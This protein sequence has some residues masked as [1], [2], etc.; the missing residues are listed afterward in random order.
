[1]SNFSVSSTRVRSGITA[2]LAGYA[3]FATTL[4]KAEDA[5]A[6]D[7]AIPFTISVDGEKVAGSPSSR[8]GPTVEAARALHN[9]KT[10]L[11]LRSADIQVKFDGLDVSPILNVS[12]M[13]IRRA[14]KAGE[15]V[16]FLATSNYPAFIE[17]SEIRILDAEHEPADKP[18]AVIPVTV[19]GQATWVMPETKDDSKHF[20]YV[21]RVYDG[22]GRY[23]ETLPRTLARTDRELPAEGNTGHVASSEG[24][25]TAPGMA[26]DNTARRNIP[27]HG[28]AVT[29]Y[30][31]NV[32]DG[33]KIRALGD[34]IPV[35]PERA[36][37]MQ[38]ILPPGDHD[39]DVALSGVSKSG[40]LDFSRHIVIP[41]NDWFYVGLADLTV[42]K[43]FG[44]KDIESVRPGEYDNVY[45]KGRLAFYVKGKIK[46]KYLLTAA[47][48][49][50]ET[51]LDQM[52]RGLDA[53]DPRQLLRRI[54]PEDYYPIYGDDSSVVDD[55]PTNGKFYVRL[56]RGGSHVMWGNYKA[57]IQGTEFM[58]SDRA[59]YGASGVYR[60][61]KTTSFGERQTEATVYA[62]QPDTLPQRDEF[63]GTGGFAYFMKRQD[64]TIGSETVTV[65]VRDEV[66]GLVLERRTLRYGEDYTFDYLQGM[67]ILKRPLSSTTGT[68]QPVRDGALGGNKVYLISQYEFTPVAGTLDGYVYGGRAQHWFAD[69]LR[70]GITGMDENTGVANQQAYGAD[71]QLRYSETTFIEAELARSKG[72]GFGTSRSAD[73]GL[74]L[75]DIHTTGTRNR[76]AGS[77]RTKAQ[78]DLEDISRG[79]IKGTVGGYYE[80]KQAGF[81]TLAEQI[82]VDERIFGAFANIALTKA[83]SLDF[84][85]DD[86]QEG[87][88]TSDFDGRDIG[89]RW[90]RKGA[91]AISWQLDEYWK[92]SFGLTYTDLQSPVARASRKSGQNGSRLDSGA[93]LE[94]SPDDDHTYYVFGQ[95]TIS[96]SGDIDRNDRIGVGTDYELT[97]KISLNG[98]VSYGNQGFGALA[99]INYHPTAD[100]TYYVGYRLD[101]DRAFDLDRLYDLS[102]TDRGA[103]VAGARRK[104]DDTLSVYAERNYDLFGSRNSL[105]QTYGVV[106][107]PDKCWTIDGG[108]EAGTIEDD[109]I[110]PDDGLERADFDRRAVSLAIGY[111]DEERVSARIR[112]EAR[113]EDSDDNSRD[114]N[115]YLIASGL[116]WKTSE[117][118]RLLANID[119]VLSDSDRETAFRDGNYIELSVGYAYRPIKNDRLNA[120][121]K[122]GWLRDTPGEDQV[123]AISGD[124]FGPSQRSHILSADINYDLFPWLT[125]GGKYGFRYGE[126]RQRLATDREAFSAWETSSAHLGILRADVTLVKSWDALVEARLLAMPEADT[127]DYGALLALYRHVGSN[128]KVGVG[129][130]FGCFSDDLRD[131]VLNDEGVFL[132]VIG[133]F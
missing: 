132:N 21:L 36:F 121:F 2:L 111:K 92:A 37:V 50:T 46:G 61:E 58:R 16:D 86:Y 105:T 129:Y 99:A 98:E 51:D 9:R 76:V 56:D 59:L 54:D 53:K 15:K 28:G 97:D 47:A 117:D 5:K 10:D 90:K 35:D 106:Y 124:E 48:D 88:G 40:G 125:I 100:D 128:F 104:L 119:A 83:V 96:R 82:S 62:A 45:T 39:I 110:D 69:K 112:G 103:I 26:E 71:A 29:V 24:E 30:G 89:E 94:Y 81:S 123:S 67:L 25:A 11:G 19:N 118:W 4:A 109:A 120:L 77:W 1:M 64:I 75:S 38:R 52:F 70:I 18:I 3:L 80:Q 14:Y 17:K 122:Y 126:T 13:P 116:S 108:F 23:D 68:D 74:T 55:A 27:V 113:F 57:S 12:T 7:P 44:D 32:P 42:G 91:S 63:L 84:N 127:T 73:G 66:T 78:L 115:T 6:S 22:E 34:A 31:R 33:Y 20:Q 65:E 95:G 43:R 114:A 49:T 60:S 131:L 8:T 72:P 41:Q 102:G 87:R 107:T 133:K 130:N 93:R 101:P 79:G 85:Y